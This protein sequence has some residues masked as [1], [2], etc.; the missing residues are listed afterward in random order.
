MATYSRITNNPSTL[1]KP[2]GLY[3]QVCAVNSSNLIF[4]A[5]QV[6][7]NNK[8]DLVGENDIAAQVTQ[9]YQNIADAL[10]SA[11]AKFENIVQ[12]TTYIVGADNIPAFLEK[13]N[14]IVTDIYPASDFPPSTLLVVAGLADPG[15]LAE[16]TAIAALP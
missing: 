13:R 4:L 6:S 2:L 5:G 12:L 10:D 7:V 16:V 8:G 15:Y 11:D 9:I 14:S 3:S 1:S